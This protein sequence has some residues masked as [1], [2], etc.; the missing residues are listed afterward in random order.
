MQAQTLL[1]YPEFPKQY[2]K[3]RWGVRMNNQKTF[4]K[5]EICFITKKDMEN[6]GR[7]KTQLSP[8]CN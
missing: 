3:W 4:T 6:P 2:T 8:M 5:P 7:V 1:L